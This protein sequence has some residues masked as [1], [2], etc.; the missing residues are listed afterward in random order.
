MSN[1]RR[2]LSK[3]TAT[4]AIGGDDYQADQRRCPDVYPAG[5]HEIWAY[6]D[7]WGGVQEMDEGNNRRAA[8]IILTGPAVRQR[9]GFS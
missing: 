2:V 3:E 9:E 5:G 7:S 8:L 6:A 1:R 4:P